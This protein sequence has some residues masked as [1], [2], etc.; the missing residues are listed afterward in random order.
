ME[1]MNKTMEDNSMN[2][3]MF[4]GQWKQMRGVVKS[5]WGELAD[6]DFDKIGGQKD[7][8][9]GLIQEKYGS[10]RDQA[11]Q[12]VDRRLKEYGDKM[13]SRSG[14]GIPEPSETVGSMTAKA[15]EVGATAGRK[16]SEAAIV[17]GEKI[18]SLASVIR[19]NA[20]QEG[21]IAR[22][23]TAV[24]GGLESAS[25]YLQEKKFAELAKDLT[26]LVR[27]YPVQSVLVGV[28]LGYLLARSTKR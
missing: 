22:A 19:K 10:T 8:L 4:A 9:I 17:V 1:Q 2:Q 13:A 21:A 28:G 27:S 14:S 24:A 26:S 11:Q 5:W 16:A 18:G 3:E 25:S 7:K 23:A 15:Q 12:E 20:P 6:D